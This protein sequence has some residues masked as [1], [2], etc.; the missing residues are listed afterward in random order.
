MHEGHDLRLAAAIIDSAKDYAIFTIDAA[1]VITSWSSGAEA[2]IGYGRD[3]VIG[4]HF[5][6]LF[7]EPDLC[8]DA[9]AMEIARTL[10]EGRAEDT[11]WHRR[12]DG[13]LFWANG[14]TMLMSDGDSPSLLKVIRDETASRR[15]D[16]QRV[17]LLHELNH[18]IKNTLATV[19]SIADQ[20]LRG[21]KVDTKVRSVLAQ[22]LRA[23]SEAHDVLVD[24]NW[25]GADLMAIV[26]GALDPFMGPYAGR[27]AVGGPDI[28]LAPNQ[29]VAVSLALHE[30]A[31]NAVKYGALST[32]A[33]R[34]RVEWNLAQ[35]GRGERQM[36]LLWVE[37]GGPAVQ[38]P[39]HRGFGAR[40]LDRLFE[41]ETNGEA[42]IDFAPEGLRC[43]MS[44]SLDDRGEPAPLNPAVESPVERATVA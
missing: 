20:T 14:V 39:D 30:L 27:L 25:A 1:G 17:L 40:L 19:Q 13:E 35:N 11:R 36:N 18:R 16:E 23:V 33:G 15:A 42:K 9:P 6:V 2:V 10:Q 24:Q 43:S 44:L 5:A 38:P 32:A 37:E 29:A 7:T 34:I 3:E 21:A 31:T 41:Q 8:A 22:R 28:R 12:K 4:M 26:A